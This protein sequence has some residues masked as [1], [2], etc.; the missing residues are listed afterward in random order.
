[1]IYIVTHHDFAGTVWEL[2][3]GSKRSDL[4]RLRPISYRRLFRSL[5]APVGHYIF[6]DFDRLSAYEVQVADVIAQS[7]AKAAPEAK[8]L[9]RPA[10][11]LERYPLL[12]RLK[13]DG[14]NDFSAYRLDSGEM[15]Q[16][17]PVFVRCEDDCRKPDTPLLNSPEE[18]GEAI[19]TLVQSGLS[20]KRRIAVEFCA[21]RGADGFYRKYGV[22]KIGAHLIPHHIQREPDWYVK[23]NFGEPSKDPEFATERSR[24]IRENPH[25]EQIDRV[26]A[27]ANIDF[28]RIDYAVVNGKVQTYEINTNPTVPGLLYKVGSRSSPEQRAIMRERVLTALNEIDRPIGS[29]YRVR[30]G[31]PEPQMQKFDP[32]PLRARF[33]GLY[34]RFRLVTGV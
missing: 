29:T 15:P 25:A 8:V 3:R 22:I 26:F 33:A 19:R 14:L 1:M 6:T 16:R 31:L 27:I 9:N 4:R 34:Q 28:G 2:K 24:F 32:L 11:V 21:E 12:K 7:I 18:L 23:R 30:F 10:M 13:Q 20:M 17:Y 5:R